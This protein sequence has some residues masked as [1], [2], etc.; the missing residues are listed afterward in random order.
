MFTQLELH[1]GGG[2]V[3]IGIVAVG[4]GQATQL[5]PYKTGGP[6]DKMHSPL[7][8]QGHTAPGSLHA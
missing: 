3:G 2:D 1:E 6:A 4:A 5:V 7:L 8:P